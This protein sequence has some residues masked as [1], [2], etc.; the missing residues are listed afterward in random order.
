[1]PN[2]PN[3]NLPQRA[4]HLLI[5]P[6]LCARKLNVHVAV[7]AY[8]TALVL[9]LAPFKTDDDL[10]IDTIHSFISAYDLLIL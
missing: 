2:I 7:D 5:N 1:V 8:E 4:R 6:L 3:Q 9:G 10:F